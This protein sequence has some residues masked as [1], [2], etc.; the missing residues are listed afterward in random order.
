VVAG[1]IHTQYHTAV[2]SCVC[3]LCGGDKIEGWMPWCAGCLDLMPISVKD[4]LMRIDDVIEGYVRGADYYTRTVL[5]VVSET[6]SEG[7]G[8]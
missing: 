6:V 4:D 3:A 5:E 8:K 1:H 7:D 2:L